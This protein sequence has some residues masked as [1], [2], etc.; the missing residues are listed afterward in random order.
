MEKKKR[1]ILKGTEAESLLTQLLKKI[2]NSFGL[3][4]NGFILKYT[5]DEGDLITILNKCDLEMAMIICPNILHLE[6]IMP[7]ITESEEE[8]E[9]Q[10]EQEKEKENGNEQQES[11]KKN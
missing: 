1:F 4:S 8:Q 10:E 9:E 5:D 6:I 2:E 7:M 11:Q 3:E